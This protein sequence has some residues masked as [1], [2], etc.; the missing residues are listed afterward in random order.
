[1]PETAP[2]ANKSTTDHRL[3]VF[4]VEDELLD[5]DFLA[6]FLGRR[7]YQVQCF[8]NAESFLAN[9]GPETAGC[10]VVDYRLTG[11]NGIELVEEAQRRGLVIPFLVCSG[12]GDIRVV[13]QAFHSGAIDFLEKPIDITLLFTLVDK[14]FASESARLDQAARTAQRDSMLEPLTDR[15]KEV[16]ILACQ[17]INNR[18]IAL[19]LNISHRTVEAHK[20]RVIDKLG[21]R[22]SA[23]LIR[24]G[25]LIEAPRRED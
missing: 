14:A 25:S 3:T 4:V 1:M 23:D 11:M 13:R 19:Q 12:Y 7:G 5:R 2:P 10:V 18:D 6:L 21:A 16:A 24:M 15:E 9:A 17:G 22:T 20:S 8:P